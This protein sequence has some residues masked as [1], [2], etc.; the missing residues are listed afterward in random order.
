MI[1]L[2]A[3]LFEIYFLIKYL[4]YIYMPQYFHYRN[5]PDN[6]SWDE[7]LKAQRCEF[8]K[9]DGHRCKRNVIIGVPY[10]FQHRGKELE[11]KVKQSTIHNA[12]NGLFAFDGKNDNA[13][14]F[15][16]NDKITP[17]KG[18]LVNGAKIEERYGSKTAPYGLHINRD[19]YT[20]GATQ[21]GLG[22][23]LNHKTRGDNT[24]FS[25]QRDHKEVNIV[26]TKNIK[27]NQELFVNYGDEFKFNEQGTRYS[28]NN[29][30]YKV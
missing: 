1:S 2:Y 28:T 7:Q 10:C 17:Y 30:K 29:A 20:D 15:H 8:H 23:L 5:T 14:V 13:V 6:I 25:V 26:A 12:G 9:A 19:K 16:K 18:Q 22:T 24:R 27:N 3:S 21:R 4:N 11:I